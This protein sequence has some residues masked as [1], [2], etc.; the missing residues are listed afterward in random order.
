WALAER[1]AAG[2]LGRRQARWMPR[3]AEEHD[4]LRAAIEWSLTD[5]QDPAGGLAIVCALQPFWL[6]RHLLRESLAWDSRALAAAG[7]DVPELRVMALQQMANAAWL[8]VDPAT[9]L[10]AAREALEL[11]REID[12]GWAT[13]RALRVLALNTALTGDSATGIALLEQALTQVRLLRDGQ[14]LPLVLNSLGFLTL[15]QGDLAGARALLL[16][17]LQAAR[18]VG[19]DDQ[20]GFALLLLGYCA[21][22]QGD[23]AE[24]GARYAE[25]LAVAMSMEHL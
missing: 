11:A 20:T 6:Y 3:L 19:F 14:L 13:V 4:N 24:T 9:G 22:L 18:A 25:G 8:V 5:G 23:A 15:G 1:A 21:L 10:P 16:E 17:G 7:T 12:Q 2:P